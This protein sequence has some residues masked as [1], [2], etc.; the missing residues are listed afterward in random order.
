MRRRKVLCVCVFFKTAVLLC[1]T[2][3]PHGRH[4]QRAPQRL[5][6][7]SATS[8]SS[9]LL[10]ITSGI[11]GRASVRPHSWVSSLASCETQKQGSGGCGTH[12]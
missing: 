4:T 6:H 1:I 3:T 9:G 11:R 10:A 7:L 2:V 12:I 8:M 5:N